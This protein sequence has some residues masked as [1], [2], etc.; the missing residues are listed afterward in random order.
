MLSF[1]KEGV[2]TDHLDGKVSLLT[3]LLTC[4]LRF[5]EPCITKLRG[6]SQAERAVREEVG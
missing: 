4:E 2:M 3:L 6:D 1:T 5:H